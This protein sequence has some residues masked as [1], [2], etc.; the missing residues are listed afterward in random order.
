MSM[1]NSVA[2]TFTCPS[3][4]S[5][6]DFCFTFEEGAPVGDIIQIGESLLWHRPTSNPTPTYIWITT[7]VGYCK[8]CKKCILAEV[9]FDSLKLIAIQKLVEDIPQTLEDDD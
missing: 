2:G 6:S 7:G 3:C 9:V 8:Y 1:R 4:Q 5:T